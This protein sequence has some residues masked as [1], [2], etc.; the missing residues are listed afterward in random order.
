M[1]KKQAT[2]DTKTRNT[3]PEAPKK[4]GFIARTKAFFMNDTLR[5]ITGL[6]MVIFGVYLLLAFS[7]FFVTGSAD[8]SII[9]NAS[10]AQLAATNNGVKN[11]AGSR[12]AQVAN[13]LINDCFGLAAFF[14]PLFLSLAGLKLMRVCT[15]N[16]KRWFI[17]CSLLLVWFSVF[18][19]FTFVGQY[20][21]SF[22]LWGGR[23]GYNA[24]AWL[25][26]QIGAPGVWLLLFV[27]AVCF[28]IYLSARTIDWLRKLFSLSFLKR[29]KKEQPTEEEETAFDE[30]FEDEPTKPI[31]ET[32]EQT[33]E[34]SSEE[35]TNPAEE[36]EPAEED[37]SIE[38][39]LED[40]PD[41]VPSQPEETPLEVVE[42]TCLP[43]SPVKEE[44]AAEDPGFTIDE[45]KEN[46]KFVKISAASL[47]ESHPHDI[48]ITKEAPNYSVNE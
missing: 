31:E 1:L 20:E 27:T 3:A 23:H 13:Y 46:G 25:A 22:L 34:E 6:L 41:E 5:F 43:E 10:E 12:G 19:G 2:K 44:E 11:Y 32:S 15:V 33:A 14:I 24:G 47:K 37:T 7:S 21:D 45:L 38:L 8:Q 18:L 4:P 29:K 42:E 40:I 28:L 39:T 17:I 16:L 48:H 35:E 26:S 36:E 30:P 9:E